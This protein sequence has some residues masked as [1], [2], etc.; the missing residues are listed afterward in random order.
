VAAAG[1]RAAASRAAAM[2]S[3]EYNHLAWKKL[4]PFL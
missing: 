3:A 4:V 1:E 2:A